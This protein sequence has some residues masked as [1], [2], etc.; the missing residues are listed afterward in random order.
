MVT[1]EEVLAA[2]AT[3]SGPRLAF[4]CLVSILHG[5]GCGSGLGYAGLV[6]PHH[7]N[8]SSPLLHLTEDQGSWFLS[9]SPLAML[10]GVLLSIPAS[11]RLG[12]T[13]VFLTSQA[14]SMLGYLGL[15][16]APSFLLLVVARAVQCGGIGLTAMTTGVYLTEISTVRMRGPVSGCNMTS[17]VIG[18]LCY[19]ALCIVLPIQ[20]LPLVLAANCVIVFVLVLVLPES[21]QWL[22]RHGRE[23]QAR[24]SLRRLRGAA[25]PGLE[26]ELE[27]IKQ[28][29]K[30]REGLA[31]ASFLKALGTR[32]FSMPISIFTVVF[33][34]LGLVGND[35]MIFYGPTIASKIDIGLPPSYLATLPWVGFT[36]GYALSSPLMARCG[37]YCHLNAHVP[38]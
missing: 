2:Q 37:P 4:Y 20:L 7:V 38:G 17:N 28:C 18:L 32:T 19:T 14:L 26:V 3:A 24:A 34:C 35:T 16:L 25:Y 29:V 13:K 30:E 8:A 27:E 10:F 11:E 12:R 31:K 22:V 21:P 36:A 15:Y 33:I 9:V 23:E 1:P 5:M 6:L